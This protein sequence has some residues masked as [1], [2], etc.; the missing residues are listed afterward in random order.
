[1]KQPC[2][3][4]DPT[5]PNHVCQLHKSLY[6]LKQAREGQMG[7]GT[8]DWGKSSRFRASTSQFQFLRG[9]TRRG[10]DILGAD[11]IQI[12]RKTESRIGP[13]VIVMDR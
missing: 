12:Y 4:E 8:A 2:R 7:I 13:F 9:K 10:D 6:G 1:M 11:P 3:F 5:K